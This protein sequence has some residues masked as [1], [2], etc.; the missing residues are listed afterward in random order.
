MKKKVKQNGHSR[1]WT[2]LLVGGGLA[3]AAVYYGP[4]LI[5]R[6][7]DEAS[8]KA[9]AKPISP[10]RTAGVERNE[11]SPAPA[12]P[13]PKPTGTVT[14]SS[15][16][17]LF[18]RPEQAVGL[19][20][21]MGMRDS[22]PGSLAWKKTDALGWN[23]FGIL[24]AANAPGQSGTTDNSITC[25]LESRREDEVEVVRLTAN[26][27]H[28]REEAVTLSQFKSVCLGF[29]NEARCPV[30]RQFVDAIGSPEG[31]KTETADGFFSLERIPVAQGYR[32]ELTVKS[33]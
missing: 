16:I 4:T 13:K 32:V 10:A 5:Q 30:T 9:I 17:G 23:S 2:G 29:L 8:P 28:P 31:L 20:V 15:G 14:S 12:K 19:P 3:G 21:R 26:I 22:Y 6:F 27:G 1:F 24:T 7:E 25:L 11:A 33:K 18:R